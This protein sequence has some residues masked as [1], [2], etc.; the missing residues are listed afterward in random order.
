M[1][2]NEIFEKAKKLGLNTGNSVNQIENLR[3]IA[4]QVG[5]KEISELND[6][7]DKML[8][9]N[10][11]EN[12]EEI[13][14]FDANEKEIVNNANKNNK[15]FTKKI[16]DNT[17]Q[18]SKW[19]KSK[20]NSDLV[21]KERNRTENKI[22][23]A[24]EK[25]NQ[26][27]KA[28]KEIN[29]ESTEEIENELGKQIT[30]KTTKIINKGGEVVGNALSQG[31]KKIISFFASNPLIIAI[32]FVII[33]I[34]I[35][36]L[37]LFNGYYEQEK[38]GYYDPECNFNQT[39]VELTK[40]NSDNKKTLTLENYIFGVSLSYIDGKNYSEDTLKALMVILKTNALSNGNYNNTSKTLYLDDCEVAYKEPS[41]VSENELEKVESIYRSVEEILYL[42]TS[43]NDIITRLSSKNALEFNDSTLEEI[44]KLSEN[45][46]YDK[47]LDKIYNTDNES[48]SE[49]KNENN[50]TI[51]VGDSR[52]QSM[53]NY[54]I[55]TDSNSVFSN[56]GTLNWFNGNSIIS[57]SNCSSNA[58][59]CVSNKLKENDNIVI[60]LGIN[61][62]DNYEVYYNKYYNLAK[63]EWKN[64]NIYIVSVGY[65]DE[66]KTNIVKNSK[67]SI[68]NYELEY[69]ISKS[70]LSN[71]HFIDLG[72]NR[73]SMASQISNGVN[74][75]QDFLKKIYE[76]IE[77][78]IN[79]DSNLNEE[80]GIY[81]LGTYCT[82]Y[83]IANSNTAYWWPLGSSNETEPNIYGGEPVSTR[84]TSA[85]GVRVHPVT[86]KITVHTGIDIGAESNTPI[87]AVKDGTVSAVMSTCKVATNSSDEEAQ[88]G[89]RYGNYVLID[90]GDG[91]SSFYAHM[92]TSSAKV[93][94]GDT[95]V[96][97]QKIGEVG[98]TGVSTGPHLHF[99][100]RVNGTPTNPLE[101]V[102][103]D[104]TRPTI[105]LEELEDAEVDN[106]L[107]DNIE[108]EVEPE[109]SEE[110]WTTNEWESD[111]FTED[112]WMSSEIEE[113]DLEDD[114][115]WV[116]GE[117]DESQWDEYDWIS[118]TW[119]EGTWGNDEW[120]SG[121]DT[122]DD[123]YWESSGNW[124]DDEWD[125]DN[126]V[127]DTGSNDYGSTEDDWNSGEDIIIGGDSYE[128]DGYTGGWDD[129]GYSGGN[130]EVIE[131]ENGVIIESPTGHPSGGGYSGG[132]TTT[133]GG[134]T[135]NINNV[136]IS[137]SGGSS[138]VVSKANSTWNSMP[139]WIRSRFVNYGWSIVVSGSYTAIGQSDYG[140]QQITLG[141]S[142]TS[143]SWVWHTIPHELGHFL[144][145]SHGFPS[146]SGT[147][148]N[149]WQQEAN[150]FADPYHELD[151]SWHNNTHEFFAEVF[152]DIVLTG[153]KYSYSA[154][155]AYAFVRNYMG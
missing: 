49:N 117:W 123:E 21:R 9:L 17:S 47:I 64:N 109:W 138:S 67:I 1:Q 78:Y 108:E 13:E 83:S 20:D 116:V 99:E 32:T 124:S 106:I 12:L 60:W 139:T 101:F 120:I 10:E 15:E 103:I 149:I 70:G 35:V 150:K 82:Y 84:V 148:T 38:T 134:S 7:L 89:G 24:R 8:E 137:V 152:C 6:A 16:D 53:K 62:I 118:G 28:N 85:Y 94:V 76:K 14:E 97:G 151:E 19:D 115:E 147:F 72:Y 2:L 128:D 104:N 74:Y 22:N 92:Y 69:N 140:A 131:D 26:I 114:D 44:E 145:Y 135:G 80:K 110:E 73:N 119:E 96:Q 126:W 23:I 112:K 143:S 86:G 51:F 25:T 136:V 111:S 71:L 33:A 27:L 37:I 40:C 98:T 122:Y 59:N 121:N 3:I 91:T 56:G 87:I 55:L 61:D 154:P 127:Q 52:I 66:S 75:N 31:F 125:N 107:A 36:L 50:N 63:G 146:D 132:S 41:Q 4:D 100:M 155:Q 141:S 58:V 144:D 54:N 45:N 30:K 90:H 142:S 46:S 93:D 102:H 18:K 42:S 153:G 105:T 68:F 34:L 113:D 79:L 133:T 77:N 130:Y 81:K 5:V 29:E 65:V 48:S 95:V 57:D 11:I 88:C 39:I 43:Y 129:G